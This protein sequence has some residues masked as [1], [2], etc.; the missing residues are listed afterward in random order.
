MRNDEINPASVE[1]LTWSVVELA[2]FSEVISA[3]TDAGDHG[4]EHESDQHLDE[5]EA[6]VGV[7]ADGPRC[8]GRER[9]SVDAPRLHVGLGDGSGEGCWKLTWARE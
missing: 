1:S 6:P 5:G 7:V 3:A 8:R 4:A 9:S 2:T